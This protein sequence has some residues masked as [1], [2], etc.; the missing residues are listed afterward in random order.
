MAKLVISQ[1]EAAGPNGALANGRD[2][3]ASALKG[4]RIPEG[5]PLYRDSGRMPRED[6]EL[7]RT[8][9]RAGRLAYVVSSYA[10]PIGYVLTDGTRI[11]P[12][13][14]YSVTTSKHQGYVRAWLYG[15]RA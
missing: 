14:R 15:T 13:A 9:A 1:R 6:A 8:H 12:D 4:E 3:T 11:I 10:T 5:F 2:F 7:F